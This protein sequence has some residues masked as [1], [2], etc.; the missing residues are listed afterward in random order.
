MFFSVLLFV[1]DFY[2]IKMPEQEKKKTFTVSESKCESHQGNLMEKKNKKTKKHFLEVSTTISV[3]YPVKI[4]L[5]LV[6]RNSGK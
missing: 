6:K 4:R 2:P 3:Q 1:K 5:L